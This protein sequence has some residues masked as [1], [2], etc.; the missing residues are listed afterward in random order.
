MRRRSAPSRSVDMTSVL[1]FCCFCRSINA[2]LIQGL[3]E[4]RRHIELNEVDWIRGTLLPFLAAELPV[5]AVLF[6]SS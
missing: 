1:G 2:L 5:S 3:Y 6:S 4:S